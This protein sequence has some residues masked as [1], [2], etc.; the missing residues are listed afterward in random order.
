MLRWLVSTQWVQ[1]LIIAIAQDFWLPWLNLSTSGTTIRQ[2]LKSGRPAYSKELPIF[3]ILL[4]VYSWFLIPLIHKIS[5]NK[6]IIVSQNLYTDGFFEL[7][8]KA[9]TKDEMINQKLLTNI[10]EKACTNLKNSHFMATHVVIGV[11]YGG[12]LDL[13]F[14]TVSKKLLFY[15]REP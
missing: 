13:H 2:W 14:I 4:Y 12:A 10:D 6:F 7:T 1:T 3:D 8:Y 5:Y 15:L 9:K 11:T